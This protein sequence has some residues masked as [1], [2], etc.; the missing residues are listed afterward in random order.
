MKKKVHLD[1]Y[2][3]DVAVKSDPD[4]ITKCKKLRTFNNGPKKI[5]CNK[6]RNSSCKYCK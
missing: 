1:D 4:D 6:K 5:C 2:C 3:I